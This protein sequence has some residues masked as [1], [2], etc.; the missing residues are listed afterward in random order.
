M[1]RAALLARRPA[2]AGTMRLVRRT[3]TTT[4]TLDGATFA[5]EAVD[6]FRRTRTG[7]YFNQGV[8]WFHNFKPSLINELRFTYDWRRF[9]NQNSGAYSNLNQQLGLKGVRQDFGP[10]VTVTGYQTLGEGSNNERIQSP[11]KGSQ[12]TE[13]LLWLKGNHSLKFG[14]E[15]RTSTNDDLNRNTAGGVFGFNNVATGHGI[16]ALLLGFVQ[17]ASVKRGAAHPE[18]DRQ[19]RCFHP[20]RLEDYSEA[21]SQSRAALG[22]GYSSPRAVR[23]SHELVRH[24]RA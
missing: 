5:V 14:F 6:P 23:Q 18:P 22:H 7:K 10:R 19:L 9:V 17:N 16:A 15:R 24:V 12:I 1:G 3:A 2:T 20:G 13:N 11:I 8:T 4:N 21:H